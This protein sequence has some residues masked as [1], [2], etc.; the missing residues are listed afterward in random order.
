MNNNNVLNH[1]KNIHSRLEL[2]FQDSQEDVELA[3]QLED[4]LNYVVYNKIPPVNTFDD[5]LTQEIA[6]QL[7]EN[8]S[9]MR[10]FK[11]KS[12]KRAGKKG[13]KAFAQAI[14]EIVN[15]MQ[16][17]LITNKTETNLKKVIVGEE[18]ATV[19]AQNL[20]S[21]M[22]EELKKL[23]K[24]KKSVRKYSSW[25]ARAGKIDVDMSGVTCIGEPNELAKKL[26]AATASVKN[27]S[28]FNIGLEK[29]DRQKA[30][31]AV[32]SEIY[33]EMTKETLESSWEY[34]NFEH[35]YENPEIENHLQHLIN[36]YALTGYGQA[37]IDRAKNTIV[38]KYAKFLMVNN[39]S[40][41]EIKI[42][43]TKSII[44]NELIKNT[45]NNNFTSHLNKKNKYS[46]Y[47]NLNNK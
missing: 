27:Y 10:L 40:K 15:L 39:R 24:S 18:S 4:F 33:P 14:L 7:K 35:L 46:T 45:T 26:I 8:A 36:L 21:D 47:Y 20:S 34:Y 16:P 37:Y 28:S 42:Q 1:L 11:T 13:E 2:A 32:I 38:R 22:A 17:N 43:S 23:L 41:G 5:F 12:S 31:M 6:D 44:Y 3:K 29:V 30:Y 19:F 9:L 25:D